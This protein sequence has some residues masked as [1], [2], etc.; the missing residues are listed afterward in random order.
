MSMKR[1]I[2]A[3]SLWLRVPL[4]AAVTVSACQDDE[5]SSGDG[6]SSTG[7]GTSSST[8]GGD[9]D[10][11]GATTSS[12]SGTETGEIPEH[13]MLVI[14]GQNEE[15]HAGAHVAM[16]GD[17]NGDGLGDVIVVTD[18]LD[19]PNRAYVVFG[20]TDHN[21]V[22]LDDIVTGPGGFIM[23]GADGGARA[24]DVNADGLAD[25]VDLGTLG[26][27]GGGFMFP[28]ATD[29]DAAGDFN[30]DGFPDV[31]G[32]VYGPGGRAFVVHGKAETG[33]VT[34]ADLEAGVG[35]LVLSA[36]PGSIYTGWQV[37]GA[38]DVNGDGLD[39]VIVSDPISSLSGQ[40]SGRVYVVFG[41]E[42]TDEIP[43]ADV[44]AGTGGFTIDGDSYWVATG[45]TLAGVGDVNGDGRGDI[46]ITSG[47][48]AFVVFGRAET[49]AVRVSE[50]ASSG[51]GF[52]IEVGDVYQLPVLSSAGDF[53][54]DGSVDLAMGLPAG[55]DEVGRASVV[56]GRAGTDTVDLEDLGDNGV[57][58]APNP[59]EHKFG[60]AVGGG[61]DFDGDGLDDV[62]I[63][64]PRAGPGHSPGRAY[65]LFGVGG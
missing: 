51:A 3:P 59:P 38:G 53:D 6:G 44:V 60:A 12:G 8:S 36:E 7:D 13:E 43:L 41:R 28:R 37:S 26:D 19:P 35:G 45:D 42:E 1:T 57:I 11:G 39:D 61:A 29:L 9:T 5:G 48:S 55:D 47:D 64:S 10:G 15:D 46:A 34:V 30:G 16:L 49:S 27:D 50:I 21:R 4:V 54:G 2:Q 63:G 18:K 24:G 65:V 62:V 32:G 20:K 33:E 25:L 56:F 40:Y 23:I 17:V 31:I 58:A 52:Q 22:L 14:E